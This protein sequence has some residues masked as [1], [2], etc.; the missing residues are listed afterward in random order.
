MVETKVQETIEIHKKTDTTSEEELKQFY[1]D[2]VEMI[3]LKQYKRY[4]YKFTAFF[5]ELLNRV[6]RSKKIGRFDVL[7]PISIYIFLRMELAPLTPAQFANSNIL[8][9]AEL[10]QCLKLI[11]PYVPEYQ[12]RNKRYLVRKLIRKVGRSFSF[13]DM[14]Y[15]Y[16]DKIMNH[17]WTDLSNTTDGACA[18]T[19][20]CLATIYVDDNPPSFNNICKTFGIEM[21]TVMYQIKKN[22][23][24]RYDLKGY[25]TLRK[26]LPLVKKFLLDSF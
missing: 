26:S 2:Y 13:P 5:G 14:F 18:A 24:E 15:Y 7:I 23:V 25:T 3:G 10:A 17:Y 21:S 6:P 19:I 1:C 12:T 4:M 22:V 11:L 9:K 20:F 8:S 16:T